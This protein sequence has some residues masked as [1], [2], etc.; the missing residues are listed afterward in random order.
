MF[1]F[2]S[3]KIKMI[4]EWIKAYRLIVNRLPLEYFFSE[5]K[6]KELSQKDKP[7]VIMMTRFSAILDKMNFPEGAFKAKLGE[8]VQSAQKLKEE[9]DNLMAPCNWGYLYG[10]SESN[11]DNKLALERFE[12]FIKKARLLPLCMQV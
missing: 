11:W 6:S 9:Y 7:S 3:N 8:L 2:R 10:E 4:L 5:D 12:E 1:A